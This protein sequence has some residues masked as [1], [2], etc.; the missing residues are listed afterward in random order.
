MTSQSTGWFIF[1]S[2][3]FLPLSRSEIAVKLK[4]GLKICISARLSNSGGWR[5]PD[6]ESL[7]RRVFQK[8][9]VGAVINLMIRVW[10][11]LRG[12]RWISDIW[13]LQLCARLI[14]VSPG[15]VD[16][17]CLCW[18]FTSGE[19]EWLKRF[20]NQWKIS[21]KPPR[22]LWN[23]SDESWNLSQRNRLYRSFCN[24]KPA[25]CNFCLPLLA[26]RLITHVPN[27]TTALLSPSAKKNK[28][29]SRDTLSCI[30]L[31]SNT[32]ILSRSAINKL[33]TSAHYRPV[34]K[35]VLLQDGL[36]CSGAC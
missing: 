11:R 4:T 34:W 29:S 3:C 26:V 24:L 10:W 7:I 36:A 32:H 6:K 22:S 12:K 23:N 16:G 33:R 27:R 14:H 17:S 1:H 5:V 35:K 31:R 2:L 21:G 18:L 30:Y 19:W 8:K 13:C 28:I 20:N 25:V 9:R 15:S